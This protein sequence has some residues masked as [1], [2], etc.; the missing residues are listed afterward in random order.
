MAPTRKNNPHRLSTR[1]TSR[2][3]MLTS[4]PATAS[5]VVAA[6]ASRV[7][8][9]SSTG[10]PGEESARARLFAAACNPEQHRSE[11]P[12]ARRKRGERGDRLC[13]HQRTEPLASPVGERTAD[14]AEG[15]GKHH[16]AL[17]P[18]E[19]AV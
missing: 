3:A 16:T 17:K 6:R 14:Y 18:G 15:E 13:Q 7:A 1:L 9:T 8:G 10:S 19:A 11:R 5:S 2:R 12:P 4:H